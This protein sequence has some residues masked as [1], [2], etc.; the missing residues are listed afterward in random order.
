MKQEMAEHQE[1]MLKTGDLKS[2]RQTEWAGWYL[3]NRIK[4]Y[5]KNR[6][7]DKIIKYVGK[8]NKKKGELDFD[9]WFDEF[10]FYGDVKASDIKEKKVLGNDTHNFY[11]SINKYDRFWYVIYEH[12]TQKEKRNEGRLMRK[13]FLKRAELW[14]EPKYKH[15][16]HRPLKTNVCFK[17][18]MIIELNRI[19]L[20]NS[21][22][23]ENDT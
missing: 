8:S 9:L 17:S 21:F 3:E 4:I 19:F 2:I 15:E 16:K 20:I 12:E 6:K 18:M 22:D 23:K 13:A 11:E 10:Q 1:I 7:L 14:I 5:L